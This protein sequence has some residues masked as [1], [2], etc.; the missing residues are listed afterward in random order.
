L[1]PLGFND[2]N[3]TRRR[4][5]VIPEPEYQSRMRE[6]GSAAGLCSTITHAA[7]QIKGFMMSPLIR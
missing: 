2:G 6:A 3:Q 1:L 7:E 5:L 4:Q